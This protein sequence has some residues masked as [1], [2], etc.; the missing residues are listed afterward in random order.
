LNHQG[1]LLA[2]DAIGITGLVLVTGETIKLLRE[3][4]LEIL[5]A[6]FRVRP[7]VDADLP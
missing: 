2:S 1:R 4:R 6:P 7:M 3:R 5:A